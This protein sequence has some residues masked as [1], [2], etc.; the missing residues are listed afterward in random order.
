VKLLPRFGRDRRGNVAILFALVLPVMLLAGAFAVDEGSLYLERRQAQSVADLA[1]IAAATN[2]DKAL[3]TAFKMFQANGLIATG[4]PFD[5]P[6]IQV[7]SSHPVHV[8]TGNYK[9]APELS[10]TARFVP[11]GSPTNAVQVTYKRIGTLFLA[12]RWQDAPEISVAAL[13]TATPQAAFSVGSRLASLNGGVANALLNSLLGTSVALDVMSYNALLDAKVDVLDF[14]D[15]LNQ[16]LSLSA[17]TYDDVIKASASRGAIAGALASILNGT[18]KTAAQTLSTSIADTGTI[19]LSKLLDLGP[20]S[21]LKLGT[22]PGYFAGVS[23]LQMLNAAGVIAGNGKQIDL[24][25][26]ATVP[27][28][29]SLKLTV[30][31]GEPPQHAWYVVGAKG[32]V[33]RTAQTRLKLTAKLTGGAVLLGATVTLPIYVE[34]AYAEAKLRSATCPAFGKQAGT[35]VVDVLP[36]AARIAIGNL[37]GSS[38]TD[39]SAFPVVDE[40]TILSVPLALKIKAK[41]AVVLGQTSPILLNFS[42]TDVQQATLKTAT[43]HALVG[44][45]SKSLIDGLDI[46]VEVLGIGLSPKAVIEAAV[47]ALVAPLAPVLDTSIFSVLDALG[48]GIGEADVRVY[49][50]TCNRPV[51]VG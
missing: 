19:P 27:G 46:K 23:A 40:A 14:L 31:I 8:V 36:G 42:A 25:V 38:F 12:R 45:L 16:Q 6:S 22:D 41:S 21:T 44:S 5:H 7:R 47:R 17:V 37:S 48:V 18:A 32:V 11:G 39:F 34:A 29:A 4:L 49:S 30:A 50:V 13:A 51:L 35:A 2:P 10:V 1:A 15:A 28:L 3:D 43:N 9:A 24:N 20:L 26:A 33:A